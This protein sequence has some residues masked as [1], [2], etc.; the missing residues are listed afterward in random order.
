VYARILA[1]AIVGIA[2]FLVSGGVSITSFLLNGYSYNDPNPKQTSAAPAAIGFVTLGAVGLGMVGLSAKNFRKNE[3][4]AKR[5]LW[6]GFSLVFSMWIA[7]ELLW[8][9]T[10]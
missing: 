1:F 8:K 4:L 9:L 6:V 10:V 7:L 5:Q 2:I 3:T